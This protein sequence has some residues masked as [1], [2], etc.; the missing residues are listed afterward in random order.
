MQTLGSFVED[1]WWFST[2]PGQ[3]VLDATTGEEVARLATRGLPTEAM[4]RFARDVGGPAL[5]ALGFQDRGALLGALGAYLSEHVDTLHDASTVAGATAR[6][7][8][9][10]VEG[11]IGVLY[12]YASLAKRSLP[13][14]NVLR[15]G[16]VERLDRGGRFAGRH[17]FVPRRGV[18]VQINAF[19]FPVWGPLEKLAP[20]LLAGMPTIIKPA[21]QTAPVTHRLVQLIIDSGLLPPGALQLVAGGA[22]D[23]LDHL[24]PQDTIAFT[25]SAATAELLRSHPSVRTRGTHLTVETDSLNASILG[26][27]AVPGTNEFDLYVSQ[28]VDELTIKAGQRCTAIRRA[29]VPASLV[30]A[31][32]EAATERLSAVT[33][34]DPRR[35]D[36]VMG[37]LASLAQ[38]AEVR[39][40]IH[41][42]ARAADVVVGGDLGDVLGADPERGAFVAPTL[43]VARDADRDEPHRIEAFGPVATV[44][45]YRD[46]QHAAQLAA[47]GAG[48]LVASVVSA[49]A[50]V[51][52][53]LVM[54]LAPWHGRILVLD[55]TSAPAST[56][57][58]SPLPRLLHGG[59][60]RA[61]GGEELGGMRAVMR[62]LART[63]VQGTPSVLGRIAAQWVPGA[64]RHL[65]EHP[66]RKPTSALQLGDAISAGPRVV[67]ADDIAAFAA[68]SGDHFYAHTNPEAAAANPLFGGIV[69]HGYL[70]VSLAAGLFVN[71]EP[72]P[73]LANYGVD[74]L[75][76]LTPVRPGDA[77]SVTLTA[78]EITPRAAMPYDEVRWDAEVTRDGDG[79]IVARYDVLTMVARTWPLEADPEAS[80]PRG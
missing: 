37:P 35:P 56:G 6:D 70:V 66:F 31:V 63:A 67:T 74:N 7:A 18:E 8:W 78:K 2:D 25:G 21:S 1:S 5:R 79:A 72:G 61:G 52:D 3:P 71:P 40:R 68:L 30:G 55:A 50:R 57:H 38:R 54:E 75:R 29:L 80:A 26:P 42:L 33:V 62:H 22:E 32:V 16:E 46:P 59:P 9:F 28:L 44:L 10:D 48:S 51:V 11:G 76:F 39:T 69:A 23:L 45:G 4:V 36:V 77:L 47:R 65:G 49:D 15:D 53:E 12:S 43:L 27:D 14:G 58:G 41:E 73:V 60:G 17:I 24:G 19:N 64:P 34:G 20:A 13:E